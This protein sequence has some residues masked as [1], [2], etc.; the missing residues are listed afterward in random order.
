MDSSFVGRNL[1][2]A[3]GGRGRTRPSEDRAALS[4]RLAPHSGPQVGKGPWD[5]ELSLRSGGVALGTIEGG[6]Q[7]E[8]RCF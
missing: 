1:G 5:N 4:G 7:N 6:P 2:G 3:G 8:G